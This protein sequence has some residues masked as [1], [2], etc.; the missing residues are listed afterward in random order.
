MK[1]MLMDIIVGESLWPDICKPRLKVGAFEKE[2]IMVGFLPNHLSEVKYSLSKPTI[3]HR[4]K[5]AISNHCGLELY[6]S[7]ECFT[8]F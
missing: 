8:E 6:T 4:T 5:L 1:S 7:I 3:N 2:S